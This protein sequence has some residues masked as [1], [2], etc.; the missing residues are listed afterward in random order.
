MYI[1]NLRFYIGGSKINDSQLMV[2][3]ELTQKL[4]YNTMQNHMELLDESEHQLY[5]V[6]HRLHI[7]ANKYT[8]KITTT[9]IIFTGM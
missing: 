4:I 9:K 3:S 5:N 1:L 7:T 6:T 8:I 2:N